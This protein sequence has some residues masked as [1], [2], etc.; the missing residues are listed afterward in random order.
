MPISIKWR[1]FDWEKVAGWKLCCWG[2]CSVWLVEM[3]IKEMASVETCCDNI[4]KMSNLEIV[5]CTSRCCMSKS[6]RR[7]E[8]QSKMIQVTIVLILIGCI[9]SKNVYAP[10]HMI[11]FDTEPMCWSKVSSKLII[12]GHNRNLAILACEVCLANNCTQWNAKLQILIYMKWTYQEHLKPVVH[13]QIIDLLGY[14]FV[15]I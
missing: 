9:V 15:G 4:T 6:G 12:N 13:H 3:E 10:F 5:S 8:F 1:Q 14:W 7:I 11:R 2:V